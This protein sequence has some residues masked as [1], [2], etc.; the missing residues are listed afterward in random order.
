MSPKYIQGIYL[1]W[2]NFGAHAF[3]FFPRDEI[4]N[5]PRPEPEAFDAMICLWRCRSYP[6]RAPTLD[7]RVAMFGCEKINGYWWYWLP[8]CSCLFF[9]TAT[10][11]WVDTLVVLFCE[12]FQWLQE[13]VCSNGQVS[14]S[15]VSGA[16]R[17]HPK[18][19][20]QM[21]WIRPKKKQ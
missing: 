16:Q 2:R 4:F 11:I 15:T 3:C 18:T 12:P 17:F 6:C 9:G 14:S 8:Y 20:K 13:V 19:R 10:V 21:T 5:I 1:F 7:F